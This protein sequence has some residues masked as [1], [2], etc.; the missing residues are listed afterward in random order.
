[1][2]FWLTLITEKECI[3]LEEAMCKAFPLLIFYINFIFLG[4]SM[5]GFAAKVETLAKN[6][7][8]SLKLWP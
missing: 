5:T 4:K 6:T 1:M 3:Q 7:D 2:N 8:S